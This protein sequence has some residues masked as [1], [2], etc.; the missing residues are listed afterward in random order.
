MTFAIVTVAI[1]ISF[2]AG[3]FV[4]YVMKKAEI[5]RDE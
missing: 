2:I 5:E 1:T 3:G 4:G